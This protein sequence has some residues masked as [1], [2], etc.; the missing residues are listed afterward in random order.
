MTSRPTQIVPIRNLD[1]PV[2][3]AVAPAVVLIWTV[4]LCGGDRG[5][6][7][8]LLSPEEKERASRFV[9]DVDRA[10]FVAARAFLR[11]VLAGCVGEDPVALV[12]AYGA[13]GRPRLDG[14]GA[15][16]DFNLSHAADV[17]LL[18]VSWNSPLGVDVEAVRP[19]PDLDRLAGRV[20]H[21]SEFAAFERLEERWRT[22]A[23][24]RLWTRKEAALKAAGVGFSA[25]PASFRT[26]ICEAHEET[27]IELDGTRCAIRD[28]AAP[29][30]Y[31]AAICAPE[32]A[33]FQTATL[34]GDA[35]RR[36]LLSDADPRR[37]AAAQI[38]GGTRVQSVTPTAL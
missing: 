16:P 13:K 8:R 23:F 12:F 38:F 33:V 6:D 18:A 28:I 15:R 24:F 7:Q 19:M 17:A 14:H 1:P 35:V 27:R 25:D 32:G 22:S 26:G 36:G 11:R 4:S 31:A 21:P 10:R 2:G 29:P 30:G 34:P 5:S 3:S 9:F 20:M 37:S